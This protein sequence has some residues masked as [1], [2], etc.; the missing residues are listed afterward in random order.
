[1]SQLEGYSLQTPMT[2]VVRHNVATI[3]STVVNIR[4]RREWITRECLRIRVRRRS[5]FQV[6]CWIAAIDIRK[7]TTPDEIIIIE[8]TLYTQYSDDGFFSENA[9]YLSL[10]N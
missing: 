3:A 6:F 10:H 1:M 5:I 7:Y 4:G 2:T 9:N 8:N